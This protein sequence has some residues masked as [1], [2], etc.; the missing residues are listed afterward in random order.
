[1]LGTGVEEFLGQIEKSTYPSSLN[2]IIFEAPFRNAG[3]I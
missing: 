1:M 2:S 3:K